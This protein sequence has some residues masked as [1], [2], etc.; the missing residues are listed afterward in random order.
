VEGEGV[1]GGGWREGEEGYRGHM[2]PLPYTTDRR[3]YRKSLASISPGLVRRLSPIQMKI[4]FRI[5]SDKSW[6]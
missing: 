1:E 2:P 4:T 6:E 5:A 3:I